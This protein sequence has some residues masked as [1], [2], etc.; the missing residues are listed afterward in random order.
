MTDILRLRAR[1]FRALH[2]LLTGDGAPAPARRGALSDQLLRD[3]GLPHV[4]SHSRPSSR[5]GIR[6]HPRKSQPPPAR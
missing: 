6:M 4:G 3:V 1:R 2:A 5:L